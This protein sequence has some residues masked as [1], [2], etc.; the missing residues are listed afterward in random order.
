MCNG[1]IDKSGGQEPDE[2]VVK[3]PT[4]D[5]WFSKYVQLPTSK[6]I[7]GWNMFMTSVYLVSIFID[8][9]I[10]GFHLHP[11]LTP[12]IVTTQSIAGALM[13]IDIIVKFFVGFRSQ[14]QGLDEDS[15]DEDEQIQKST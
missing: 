3:P 12:S 6:Y 13:L 7:I 4:F 5:D 11:L 10:I 15:D 9:L 2:I 1:R 8:T 14:Q